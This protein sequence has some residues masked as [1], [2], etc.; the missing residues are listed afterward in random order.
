MRG[1]WVMSMVTHMRSGSGCVLTFLAQM[2]QQS[3]IKSYFLATDISVNATKA[4]LS[5]AKQNGVNLT[6]NSSTIDTS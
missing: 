1:S 5:T 4:I 3:N 2:L 6:R